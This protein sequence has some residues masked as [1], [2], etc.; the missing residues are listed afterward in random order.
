[1]MEDSILQALSTSNAKLLAAHYQHPSTSL[2]G[3]FSCIY[4][5]SNNSMLFPFF[6]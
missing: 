2:I 5:T 4:Y 1:M 6:V 3:R